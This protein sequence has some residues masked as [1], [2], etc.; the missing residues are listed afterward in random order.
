MRLIDADALLE[1]RWDADCRCGFVQVVDVGSIEEAPTID[2]IKHGKWHDVYL[3]SPQS[4]VQ[5]CSCCSNVTVMNVG[6]IFYYC[7]LCGA[8]MDLG[9]ENE[10]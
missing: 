10:T 6:H 8:K 4:Q 7:P 2:P 1:T 9:E 3:I 5:I